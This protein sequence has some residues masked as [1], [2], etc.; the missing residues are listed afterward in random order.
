MK[1]Q[2]LEI[3]EV[4]QLSPETKNKMFAYCFMVITESKDWGAQGY[5][6]AFGENGEIGRAVFYRASFEEMEL[7]G[8]AEWMLER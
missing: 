3:G 4:V 6:Q 2:E 5:I 8:E 7:I 1:K